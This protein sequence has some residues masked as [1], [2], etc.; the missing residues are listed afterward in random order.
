MTGQRHMR[1]L[2]LALAG[3]SL[4]DLVVTLTYM[5]TLGMYEANPLARLLAQTAAP[6]LAI[7]VFKVASAGTGILLFYLLRRHASARAM[8]LVMVAVLAWVTLQW[9]R[10]GAAAGDLPCVAAAAPPDAGWVQ[11]D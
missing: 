2:L 9:A 11:L 5:K 3:L 1:E 10:Y 7:A 4:V 6:A 8:A